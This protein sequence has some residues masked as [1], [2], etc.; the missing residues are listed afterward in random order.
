MGEKQKAQ[1][2]EEKKKGSELSKQFESLMQSSIKLVGSAFSG[3]KSNKA[4]V[5]AKELSKGAKEVLPEAKNSPYSIVAVKK[6]IKDR[7]DRMQKML[8]EIEN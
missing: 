3:K 1:A 7:N 8:D 4:A 2:N 5:S 6:T